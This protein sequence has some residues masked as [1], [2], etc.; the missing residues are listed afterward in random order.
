M[1]KSY[2]PSDWIQTSGKC[3]ASHSIPMRQI[4]MRLSAQQ[5][6]AGSLL[7]TQKREETITVSSLLSRLDTI[8]VIHGTQIR[9]SNFF[10]I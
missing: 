2:G 7:K 5:E 9:P 10:K 6:A 1:S 4:E 3:S 8:D